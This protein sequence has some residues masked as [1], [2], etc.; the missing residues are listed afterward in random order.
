MVCRG[1]PSRNRQAHCEVHNRKQL[2][3]EKRRCHQQEAQP[4]QAQQRC[5]T[6][7]VDMFVFCRP[8]NNWTGAF[9]WGMGL[10]VMERL[11]DH[12]QGP[13]Q[14]W[15]VGRWAGT[16]QF[17]GRRRCYGKAK[18]MR[19]DHFRNMQLT[20]HHGPGPHFNPHPMLVVDFDDAGWCLLVSLGQLFALG[21]LRRGP[22]MS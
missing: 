21:E 3:Q 9:W 5:S 17:A 8:G 10:R 1:G 16:S 20:S 11:A 7:G 18:N 19:A 22:E 12:R 14:K 13:V 4:R 15:A 2:R 6:D